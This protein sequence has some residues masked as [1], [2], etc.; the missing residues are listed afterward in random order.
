MLVKSSGLIGD[1][2][3]K[4]Y[5]MGPICAY[6]QRPCILKNYLLWPQ[7]FSGP[8]PQS[9]PQANVTCPSSSTCIPWQKNRVRQS[10]FTD[11]CGH[12]FY[13]LVISQS[14]LSSLC[15][16]I[17]VSKVQQYYLFLSVDPHLITGVMSRTQF[18]KHCT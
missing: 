9:S 11:F 17:L 6:A 14:Q 2:S 3:A 13:L 7:L 10:I 15:N 1:L 16:K 5:R 8:H 4:A 18:L 12:E